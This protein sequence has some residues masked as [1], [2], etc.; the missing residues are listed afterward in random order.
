MIT[1]HPVFDE[2]GNGTTIVLVPG[3]D[4]TALLFYRQI[5]LLAKHF[6]VV[7]FPLPDD[8]N[9]TMQSLMES[10]HQVIDEAVHQR[11]EKVIL[12]GES[13]GGALSLSF[14]LNYPELLGGLLI[15]NSFPLIRKR[16]QLHAAPLILKAMPWFAMETVR[17]FTQWKLHSP[18][19]LPE[20][21][22]EF[23]KCMRNVGKKG[24]VRRLEI[25]KTYDIRDRLF[26]IT[27]PTLFLA[28][29]LDRLV[30]S[31]REATFMSHQMPNAEMIRLEG[32]G[33]ICLINHDFSLLDYLL[34]WW[35]RMS[36]SFPKLNL[37]S[38]PFP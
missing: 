10:L 32:Y 1:E 9:C 31:I 37:R 6:H 24:Y 33:H 38:E 26:Q 4:G 19:A 20:D 13:F 14:A 23:H 35:T 7:T 16:I 15:V 5:P 22:K 27:T 11:K 12:C 30:P 36:E 8:S 17:K 21:L 2:Q 28:A 25:L 18:H 3:L 34:P 29:E